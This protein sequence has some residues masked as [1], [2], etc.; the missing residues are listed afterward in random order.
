MNETAS[1]DW[2]AQ[3]L[4]KAIDS[5]NGSCGIDLLGTTAH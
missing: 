5:Q 4:L 2:S 1:S 3:S